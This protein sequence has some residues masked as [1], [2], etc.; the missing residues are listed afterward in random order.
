[1]ANFELYYP[2]LKK[3]EGGYASAEFAKSINDAGGET[4]LGIARN[5][6]QD[7]EGWK[8]I[9]EYKS[10]HGI[11]KWN[12]I[13]PDERLPI[14]AKQHSKKVYWDSLKLDQFN[15][16]SIAEYVMDFGYN[17]GI[18]TSAKALQKVLGLTA[19][20][21]IGPKTIEAVNTMNQEEIFNKLVE[22]RVNFLNNI[23]K[24]SSTVKQA[25]IKRAKSFKFQK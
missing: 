12:S 19:D 21:I 17:S 14:L 18:K 10:I 13:I 25:L 2:K 24:F 7:W 11:P 16:Q 3:H 1:M 5:F 15:N 9:D 8:I 4:Y 22:Y 23:T 6:N 20:G